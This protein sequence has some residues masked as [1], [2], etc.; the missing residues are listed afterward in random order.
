ML[1]Q[2]G[3][4]DEFRVKWIYAKLECSTQI[5]AETHYVGGCP[6]LT[7]KRPSFPITFLQFGGSLFGEVHS[8]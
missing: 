5:S 1:W 3:D 4:N 8:L 7:N 6:K 2:K